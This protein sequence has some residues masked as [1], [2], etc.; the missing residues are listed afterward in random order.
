MEQ[1]NTDTLELDLVKTHY[2]NGGAYLHISHSYYERHQDDP[3]WICSEIEEARKMIKAL[4]ELI[5][6]KEGEN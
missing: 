6:I 2:K 3:W 1:T 5:K 4:E